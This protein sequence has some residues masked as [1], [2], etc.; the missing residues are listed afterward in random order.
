MRTN[1]YG[2]VVGGEAGRG[3]LRAGGITAGCIALLSLLCWPA[4]SSARD[5]LWHAVLPVGA[6]DMHTLDTVPVKGD[7]IYGIHIGGIPSQGSVGSIVPGGEV[8]P[9][10]GQIEA[11]EDKDSRAPSPCE[12]EGQPTAGN[13]VV[14]SSGNK[15][16]REVD[17]AGSE[18][19]LE[20]TWNQHWDGVGLFGY[21]WLSN[22]DYK[23]SFGSSYGIS[24][25][26]PRPSIAECQTGHSYDT[27][28]A[29]RPD[30]RKIR[31]GKAADGVYYEEKAS[32][33]SRIVRQANGTWVLYGEHANVER[34]RTGGLPLEVKDEQGI[35]WTFAYGGMQGTQLQRVT[36]TSS[37]FIQFLWSGDE[38]TQIKDPAGN[39]YRY[40]YSHRKAYDGLHLLA[41]VTLPGL[42]ATHI[43]YHYDTDTFQALVGKSYNDV[44]YSTFAYDAQR[45]ATLSEHAGGLERHTFAYTSGYQNGKPTLSVVQTNPLGKRATYTFVDRKLTAVNGQASANCPAS[46]SSITYDANGYKDKVHDHEGGVT[47]YDFNAKGQLL[48][49]VEA[50]GTPEARAT[51]YAWDPQENRILRETVHAAS[52][53]AQFLQTTYGYDARKRL[54]SVAVKNL[55]SL[56]AASRDQTRLTTYTYT[57]HPNGMVATMRVD[58]PLPGTG[59]AVTYAYST[60][61]DLIRVST[62]LGD[63]LTYSNYNALGQPGR[64]AGINGDVTEYAYDARGRTTSVKRIVGGVAQATTYAY[65]AFGRLASVTTPD[66]HVRHRA[67]DAGWRLASTYEAEPGGSYARTRYTYNNASLPTVIESERLA[68][69]PAAPVANAQFVGQTIPTIHAGWPYTITIR[70][71]NTGTST[72][73]TAGGYRLVSRGQA[74]SNAFGFSVLDMPG[75]IAPGQTATFTLQSTAPQA[76]TYGM[77]WQLTNAGV[78][79]GATTA[80]VGVAVIHWQEPAPDPCPPLADCTILHSVGPEV[81]GVQRNEPA[82]LDGMVS[83]QS[84]PNELAYRAFIDYDELGRVMARRGNNGQ[85]EDYGYDRE[86]RLL[87]KVDAQG[88]E[89]RMEYDRLGRL[90]KSI[91]ANGGVAE[92][93]Y[94]LGDRLVWVKDPRGNVTSYLYDGFGQLW[95]QT[96]PD[97][98]TTTFQYSAAGLKTRMTRHD[99]SWLAYSYDGLGRLTQTT[100]GDAT[101]AYGYDWCGNGKGRICNADSGTSTRHFGYT[102]DGAIAITRDV[103]PDSDDWTHYAYDAVGRLGGVSYP[104]GTSVGYGYHL[105]KLAVIQATINGVTRIV[106]DQ[107]QYAP[108]GAMTRMVYGNGT[109]KDREYDLDGRLT[110]THDHGWLGHTYGYNALDEVTSIQNWSR[111]QY[112]QNFGYDPLSR[113]T[114]IASPVGN[115]SF[116]FDAN[117]NR[118]FHRWNHDEGYQLANGSNRML[119]G[120]NQSMTYDGRG[121]RSSQAFGTGATTTFSYDG[122]NRLASSGRVAAFSYTNPNYAD[123]HLPAGT[124]TYSFNALGQ[125]TAKSGPLGSTRFVYGGQNTLMSEVTS[126]QWTD[127]I[128]MG[129]EPI[130]FVRGGQLYFTHADRLARPEVVTDTNGQHRWISAN[131]AYDR[132]VLGSTIGDYNLGFPGQYY[133]AETGLWYN[134]FRDYDGRTGTYLQSDPIGLA[135]GLNTYAY[136]GGN[137]VGYV[138]PLGLWELPMIPQPVVDVAAGFG[139]GVSSALTFGLYSTADARE[140]MGIDGGVDPCSD[141]YGA[142]KFAGQVQ[143]SLTGA[144]AAAKG[145]AKLSNVQQLRWLNQNRYLRFGPGKPG[146]GMPKVDMMRIGPSPWNIATPTRT[147]WTH[148]RL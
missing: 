7:R 146:P 139:D 98:G 73:S 148:W 59:D 133:D 111:T 65:D 74:F 1:A 94:D 75:T 61:G 142:A 45:R 102:P 86:G 107:F 27:I 141:A 29:H 41:N 121:N 33:I 32:P 30:G 77:Q 38:L 5:E 23:L 138:D 16:E 62:A 96:S 18:L 46:A 63:M 89:T 55:S 70:L 11:S 130:G 20:R 131:Y 52:G 28:W 144:G 106:A 34:Y 47:D 101:V 19:R 42:P 100:S 51:N 25:C 37:R 4:E 109:V 83:P 43:T 80:S 6:G 119:V 54:A 14:L 8:S 125:R 135:G 78:A 79:F 50:A 21:H 132:A 39:A 81:E 2:C 3:R 31:Y 97:T 127:H 112:N 137:P 90:I 56:V 134:G 36:H 147:W 15:I 115:Q 114:S 124:T 108:T 48:R 105:G 128:W 84:L 58:G 104:G 120:A 91:D 68:G 22:F 72:W 95:S 92:F 103:T 60:Q 140:D 113:L 76:G 26:Y 82:A 66:A 122:F 93:S 88:R 53:S 110:I 99:G 143:G 17:F 69:A 118:T 71:K 44:R 10:Y 9:N 129:N 123:I 57:E 117:G 126:G 64:V 67:Y 24:S 40:A 85:R 35:G 116:T 49:R 87:L 145:L 13:P 12:D 136:V